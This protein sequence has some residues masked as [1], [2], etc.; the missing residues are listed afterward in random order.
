MFEQ[1]VIFVIGA[2]ASNEYGLPLGN[3]LKTKIAASV[4]FRD[5]MG[6][7]AGDRELHQVV[8]FRHASEI[9]KYE[10]AGGDL[11]KN[12]SSFVSI[13]DAL[14]WFARRRPEV[15]ELGKLAIVWEILKA[16]RASRLFS[17]GGW[18]IPEKDF[19]DTWMPHFHSMA[20]ESAQIDD[21]DTFK[22]V[23]VINFNY[24]RTLEHY[25]YAALQTKFDLDA[26]RAAQFLSNLKVIRPYG[27]VGS[28]PWQEAGPYVPFGNQIKDYNELFSLSMGVKTYA[29]GASGA[30][31]IIA[32]EMTRA[33][34][35]VFL[36]FGFH[37]Q[38]MKLLQVRTVSEPWRRAFATATK[39]DIGNYDI[40]KIEIATRIGCA[41]Q[42][43]PI[44]RDDT[45][46]NLLC[47]LRTAIMAA[48]H[49]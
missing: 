40:L 7:N 15:V 6:H 48:A 39:M 10:R 24:D 16:E 42:N 12:I 33:R 38:N 37:R 41:Q 17:T 29:E 23:T 31:G 27:K 5:A 26:D 32:Q 34:M 4:S 1:P 11:A 22:N 43:L 14:N 35:I 2:G 25:L 19:D 13:D 9:D 49:L 44:V 18:E 47:N 20:M 45:A 46:R 21:L 28:L 30:E 3:E 8:A 36:G